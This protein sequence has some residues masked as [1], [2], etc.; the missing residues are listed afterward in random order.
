MTGEKIR[1]QRIP[2]THSVLLSPPGG[3]L[4][5]DKMVDTKANMDLVHELEEKRGGE[6]KFS[7]LL[8]SGGFFSGPSG[9]LPGN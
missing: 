2:L 1:V 8:R 3:F 9:H 6:K 5:S 4:R 7:G